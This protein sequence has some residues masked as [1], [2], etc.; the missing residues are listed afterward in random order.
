MALAMSAIA[1]SVVVGR[2]RLGGRW[3]W[4]VDGDCWLLVVGVV[5]CV[6]LL[7]KKKLLANEEFKCLRVCMY[8]CMSVHTYMYVHMIY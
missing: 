6:C 3:R 4:M 1:K 7:Q 5:S 2:E 8:V